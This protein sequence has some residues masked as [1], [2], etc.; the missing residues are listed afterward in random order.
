MKASTSLLIV[1]F[2]VASCAANLQ[3]KR[4]ENFTPRSK[5]FVFV[6]DSPWNSPFREALQDHGFKVLRFASRDTVISK[7]GESEYASISQ[8][9]EA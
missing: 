1:C 6:S 2:A 8:K 7:G 5:T 3:V 9:A 4:L